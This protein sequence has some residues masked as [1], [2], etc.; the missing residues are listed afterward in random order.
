MHFGKT[1]SVGTDS[2]AQKILRKKWKTI[3]LP[4]TDPATG[5]KITPWVWDEGDCQM[6]QEEI[7]WHA[8]EDVDKK[9]IWVALYGILAR[10]P[11]QKVLGPIE[12]FGAD[13]T[14]LA[15]LVAFLD[16]FDPARV[17]MENTGVYSNH[18]Y[19]VQREHFDPDNARLRVVVMNSRVIARHLIA[20]KTTD[21]VDAQR[22]A[23]LASVPEFLEPSYISTPAE[24]AVRGMLRQRNKAVQT[25]TRVKNRIKTM[26]S[27]AGL[28][29][30]FDFDL[31]G[32][33]EVVYAFVQTGMSIGEFIGAVGE[34]RV[35][36][37]VFAANALSKA[38]EVLSCWGETRLDP[39]MQVLLAGFFADLARV[40]VQVQVYDK[41]VTEKVMADEKYKRSYDC[42]QG[43]I[44]M[45]GWSLAT[46]ILESGPMARFS[47]IGQYLSYAGISNGK[48]QS[49]ETEVEKKPNP[50]SNHMLKAAFKTVA[51]ALLKQAHAQRNGK[52]AKDA[53]LAYAMVVDARGE[54]KTSKKANK[55]AAKVARVVYAVLR[56]GVP[57]D[58]AYEQ[59][60]R[61]VTARSKK[62]R[63]KPLHRVRYLKDTLALCKSRAEDLFAEAN[64]ADG[65]EARDWLAK[66]TGVLASIDEMGLVRIIQSQLKQARAA[67]KAAG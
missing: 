6:A 53:L 31:L 46:T 34:G 38:E 5:E 2:P 41:L 37:S 4:F 52:P 26:L 43:I 54:L 47:N 44:G 16:R 33:R 36:L 42:I 35:Q 29:W 9:Y 12:W 25:A 17:L 51:F 39:V 19:W 7:W 13:G 55:V 30:K 40:E 28:N 57:Y 27:S 60:R 14:G 24:F 64:M 45:G 59:H 66:I 49:S 18:P 3:G 63:N 58:P 32:E 8:G 23:Q 22:M 10:D 50:F 48:E 56:A 67:A 62:L 20:N 1:T 65:P 11:R 61:Q 15:E 21:K